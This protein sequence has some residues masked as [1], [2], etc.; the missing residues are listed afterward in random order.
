MVAFAVVSGEEGSRL[1]GSRSSMGCEEQRPAGRSSTC[2]TIG[3]DEAVLTTDAPDAAPHCVR[4]H[5][6]HR[7]RAIWSLGPHRD[8]N[9]PGAGPCQTYVPGRQ[10]VRDGLA[11]PGPV[12]EE[13]RALST[14]T[15]S[16]RAMARRRAGL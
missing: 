14:C 9:E 10:W 4:R 13:A 6:A 3:P 11:V 15:P 7:R 12:R 5:A 8:S 1:T 16:P 2:D